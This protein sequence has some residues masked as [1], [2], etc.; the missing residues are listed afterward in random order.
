[1]S[2]SLPS[3]RISTNSDLMFLY[4]RDTRFCFYLVFAVFCFVAG[5]LSADEEK[6]VE[7]PAFEG[8]ILGMEIAAD[9]MALVLDVS[10]SMRPFLPSIQ[11]QLAARTPR[12]PALHVAGTGVERPKPRPEI[13]NG[14]AP[15]ND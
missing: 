8:T 14:V 6:K 15:R 10:S 7:A 2:L 4:I 1:M 5:R 3:T 9:S 13:V 12:N 11:K